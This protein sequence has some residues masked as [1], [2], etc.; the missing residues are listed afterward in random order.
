MIF[1]AIKSGLNSFVDRAARSKLLRNVSA[2][3]LSWTVN[4]LLGLLMTPL[5]LSKLG[6][7]LFGVYILLT[8]ITGNVGFMSFGM[9]A[10][11]IKFVSETYAKKEFDKVN[12][13]IDAAFLIYCG[14]GVLATLIVFSLSLF[15]PGWLRLD[16]SYHLLVRESTQVTALAVFTTLVMG[17]FASIING[18]QRYDITSRVSI[19]FAVLSNACLGVMLFMGTTVKELIIVNAISVFV[20]SIVLYT[21]C[22]RLL[23]EVV[24]FRV[25]MTDRSLFREILGFNGFVFLSRTSATLREYVYRFL[26]G[27]ILGAQAVTYYVV[28]HRIVLAI[29]GFLGAVSSAFLPFASELLAVKD[30]KRFRETLLRSLKWFLLFSLPMFLIVALFSEDLLTLWVGKEVAAQSAIVLTLLSIGYLL[31]SWTMIP[32]NVLLGAGKSKLVSVFSVLGAGIAILLAYP[33]MQAWDL[34]GA[35]LLVIVVNSPG[36]YL[37]Y[38]FSARLLSLRFLDYVTTLYRKP[39]VAI[40]LIL[41]TL[42]GLRTLGITHMFDRTPYDRGIELL[43]VVV[44]YGLY[45]VVPSYKREP[46]FNQ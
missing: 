30:T 17:M 33:F 1:S 43:I 18:L 28:A 42:Q 13:V 46:L 4:V 41:I 45:A 39:V 25:K 34:I 44:I 5:L 29:S 8:G 3:G 32:V 27:I 16:I 40:C 9:E 22:R 2:N 12:Q 19:L 35:A 7:E 24:F 11:L 38:Y 37:V 26:I 20:Q 36:L 15:L 14:G 31:S 6:V 10:G 23:P 21:Y